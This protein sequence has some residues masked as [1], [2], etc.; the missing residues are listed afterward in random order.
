MENTIEEFKKNADELFDNY[1]KQAVKNI[2]LGH[3]KKKVKQKD[4]TLFIQLFSV[5]SDKICKLANSY[6]KDDWNDEAKFKLNS[7]SKQYI[8]KYRMLFKFNV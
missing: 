5:Y 4:A 7:L 1:K 3:S 8:L 2:N 6:V